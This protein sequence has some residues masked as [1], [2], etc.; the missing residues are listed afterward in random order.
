MEKL[1]FIGLCMFLGAIL[2]A[3]IGCIYGTIKS[4]LER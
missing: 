4:A 3:V 1:R 2:L